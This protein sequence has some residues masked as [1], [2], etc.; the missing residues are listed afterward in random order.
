ML[1]KYVLFIILFASFAFSVEAKVKTQSEQMTDA[2]YEQA[3]GVALPMSTDQIMDFLNDFRLS[4]K[5]SVEGQKIYPSKRVRIEDVPLDPGDVI[6]T[7]YVAQGYVTTV[8]FL[9]ATGS[10]WPVIDVVSGGNFTITPPE[11]NGHI[12]RITPNVRFGYGNLSI[13]LKDLEFPITLNVEVDDDIVDYRFDARVPLSGPNTQMSITRQSNIE[14]A[15][16]PVLSS[17]LEGVIPESIKKLEIID[18]N[19]NGTS[20][21]QKG[22]LMFIRTSATLLSPRWDSSASVS[23]GLKVYILKATPVLLFSEN[24]EI[25]KLKVKLLK[26]E[27]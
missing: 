20:V 11:N 15:G 21:F 3:K 6:P 16:D 14:S 25:V 18:G 24:G 22:N 23:E 12:I 8:S 9:D 7:V 19:I 5:A 4:Q 26:E 17:I 27:R 2:A 10:G 1:K 13:R